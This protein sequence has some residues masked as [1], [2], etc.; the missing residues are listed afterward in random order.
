MQQGHVDRVE[1][2]PLTASVLVV[3]SAGV[4]QAFDPASAGEWFTLRG[5]AADVRPFSRKVVQGF[6]AVDSQIEELTGGELDIPSIALIGLIF[7]G[8]Y[9]ISIGNFAAPAWYTAFWYAASIAVKADKP[10]QSGGLM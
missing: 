10:S 4:E 5:S 8:V 7:S 3:A 2:N 1:V 6:Q 9:Q